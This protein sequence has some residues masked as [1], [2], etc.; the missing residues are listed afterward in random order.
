MNWKRALIPVIPI[1]VLL[2]IL[3]SGFG[4]NPHA[5]P[6]VLQGREAPQFRATTLDG[7][8]VDTKE[9]LGKPVVVNFWSTWCEPCKMEHE[10]LQQSARAYGDAVQFVGIV[11]QDKEPAVRS[12][13]SRRTNIY[14]QMMDE[15]SRLAIEY[16]V[17]GV[18]ES[19]FVDAQG[20]ILHKEAGV[21]SPPVLTAKLGELLRGG[22]AAAG[23]QR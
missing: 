22:Q 20:R 1:A 12:Y 2:A 3:Y 15:D 17:S 7:K 16:G 8:V 19:F 23:G 4:T 10:L 11:Y 6:F 13:L 21:L 14:P 5:V 18:P 9:M